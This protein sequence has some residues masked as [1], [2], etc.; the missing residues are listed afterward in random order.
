MSLTRKDLVMAS[1]GSITLKTEIDDDG[2]KK[3]SEK[4]KNAFGKIGSIAG[5]A[6]KGVTVAIGSATTALVGLGTA[7]VS[8][9]ADLEQNIGGVQTL[10]GAGGKTI[11]EYATSV[12]KSVNEVQDEYNK[13]VKSQNTVVENAEKAYKT[14]GMS[15]NE[16][17]STVTSFSA[18]LLQSLGGDTQKAA[19]SADMAII[20]MADNANKM[21]N[22]NGSHTSCIS[23]F[24]K[25]K[26]YNVR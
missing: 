18:S 23:R 26:L 6:L 5:T 19:E 9:Y 25:T 7:S 24:C 10:F 4:I 3:G 17:M 2:V 20:D 13:L 1:D 21:R 11:E 8:S 16:Y 15:A 22:I 12:G 14:A